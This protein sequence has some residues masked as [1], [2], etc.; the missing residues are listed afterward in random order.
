[1]FSSRD[2]DCEC[3][4]EPIFKAPYYIGTYLDR[5]DTPG[6]I[7]RVESYLY[8]GSGGSKVRMVLDIRGEKK[9]SEYF[10]ISELENLYKKHEG[11]IIEGPLKP[12]LDLGPDFFKDAPKLILN[13]KGGVDF[14]K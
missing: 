1:M 6:L 11:I 7:D 2:S 5:L 12:L 3:S 14:K 13:N 8:A 9:L 4:K 10:P